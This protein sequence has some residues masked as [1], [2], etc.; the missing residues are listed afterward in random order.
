MSV[1]RCLGQDGRTDWWTRGND[2]LHKGCDKWRICGELGEGYE[3]DTCRRA[4]RNAPYVPHLILREGSITTGHN[5]YF[6]DLG[7]VNLDREIREVLLAGQNDNIAR[8]CASSRAW[9]Q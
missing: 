4:K 1:V 7:N 2:D 8:D 9:S 3:C 5:T 6:H